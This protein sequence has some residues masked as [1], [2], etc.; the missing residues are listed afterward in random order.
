[1]RPLILSIALLAGPALAGDM[2]ARQD[3]DTVRLTESPCP[4]EV[5]QYVAEGS[6]GYFRKALAIVDGK[7]FVGCHYLRPDGRV[8]VIYEDGDQGLIPLA[9][10]K[11][12]PGV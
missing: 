4:R 12:D 5:L 7:S 11:P 1:M 2:L 8:L 3:G 6:R 10:F 9:H